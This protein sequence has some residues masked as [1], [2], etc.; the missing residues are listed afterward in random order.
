M[1]DAVKRIKSD[2]FLFEA[3]LCAKNEESRLVFPDVYQN[4]RRKKDRASLMLNLFQEGG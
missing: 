2:V 1:K 3:S 4:Q